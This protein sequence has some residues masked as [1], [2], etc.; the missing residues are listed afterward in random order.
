MALHK[1]TAHSSCLDAGFGISASQELLDPPNAKQS[2]E[3]FSVRL[4]VEDS[5]DTHQQ[6]AGGRQK[7]ECHKEA[8][9]VRDFKEGEDGKGD[10]RDCGRRQRDECSKRQNHGDAAAELLRLLD[11]PSLKASVW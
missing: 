11:G 9:N 3:R 6:P 7:D 10:G 4:Q 8:G 5:G 1:I 2:Q